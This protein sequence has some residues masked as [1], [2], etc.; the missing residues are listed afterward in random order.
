MNQELISDKRGERGI[1]EAN[2]GFAGEMMKSRRPRAEPWGTHEVN[3]WDL[4]EKDF[5]WMN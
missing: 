5:R 2:A 4:N 1:R 3:G